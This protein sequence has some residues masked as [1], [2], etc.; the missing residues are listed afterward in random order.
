MR[1]R[2]GPLMSGLRSTTSPPPIMIGGA[3]RSMLR[4]GGQRVRWP[5]PL[6]HRRPPLR[7]RQVER[8]V[9]LS[10]ACDNHTHRFTLADVLLDMDHVRR[11][12]DEVAG[13]RGNGVLQAVAGV[14]AGVPRDDVD[15]ALGLAM[16][17]RSRD[18]ART[19]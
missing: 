9:R 16:V 3:R 1:R 5:R 4:L 10:R 11:Y 6:S 12:P 7:C 17:V 8:Q 2:G 18:Q 15:P 14:E 19:Q 13:L